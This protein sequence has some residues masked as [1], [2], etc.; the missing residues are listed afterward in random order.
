[1]KNPLIPLF[2]L[3]TLVSCANKEN[4]P[5]PT[6]KPNIVIIYCDDLGY[7]D[8]GY[9]GARGVQT[10]NIDSLAVNGLVFTDAHCSA[11]TCTPSRYS[12]LT[13]SYAFRNN[14]AVLPGDAPLIIDPAKGSLPSMLQKAGYKTG[15]I[16][17]WHLGLGRGEVDWNREISPGPR[18]I[19]FDYSFLI[20]ATADRVPCVFIEDQAVAG[21][22]PSDPIEV[23]YQKDFGYYPNGLEHPEMLKMQAD[24]QHSCTIVDSVSRIGYMKGGRTA[25]WKDENFPLVL[26][27]KARKFMHENQ[28]QPFFL[29]FALS[30]IHVPRMPNHRFVG[31][32]TMGRRGDD[33][34]QTDWCTGQIMRAL[35][36]LGLEKNT[37]VIFS[38]DNGPILDDGYNDQAVELLGH[39]KPAGPFR[40][41][42]YSA[43][44]AGTRMPTIVYWP[45]VVKPGTSN[46]LLSQV[47]LY[48][49]LAELTGQKLG[50]DDAPDSHAL[51]D[52][53]LGRSEKGRQVMLEEAFT[54][55]LRDGNWKYIEPVKQATPQWMKNKNVESGLSGEIQLY[56]LK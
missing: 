3:A 55:S 47:D 4:Q 49:S 10:P 34:V 45:G 17:K 8:V 25:L 23:S 53:W 35:R 42:K 44:E 36:A 22:D 41:S 40:G 51:L 28:N 1:M 12:L 50:P 11:A 33:I 9:N 16:G 38:S 27:T 5:L 31:K 21:L 20:P 19:G 26:T 7:G 14:A 48:A 30:D 29:Y 39:H 2:G 15:V 43:Y 6:H 52:A 56:N 37:L 18:E 32:S 24:T 13:G 54:L 46:A